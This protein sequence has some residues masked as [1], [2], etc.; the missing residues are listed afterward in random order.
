ME[1]IEQKEAAVND[2]KNMVAYLARSYDFRGSDFDDL[3][4]V[5]MVE[6]WRALEHYEPNKGA[7]LSSFAHIWISGGMKKYVRENNTIKLGKDILNF[8]RVLNNQIE[9]LTQQNMCVPTMQE[10]ADSLGVNIEDIWK[11]RLAMEVSCVQSSDYE[12]NDEG[13]ALNIYD[14]YGYEDPG[15]NDNY[16]DLKMAVN[17][18]DD[19]EQKIINMKFYQDQSQ[20]EIADEIG[21]N[22]VGV[23]R[24]LVKV[25]GKL[26][27]DLA[28]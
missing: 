21:T 3:Y 22:Q 6:L 24:K 15:L 16:I 27:N 12:M 19:E 17:R 9:I 26:K 28:A 8:N 5:G 2:L 20:Q 11:A 18:L 7:S 25:L 23:S 14:Y 10:V 4:Q 13:K 1:N